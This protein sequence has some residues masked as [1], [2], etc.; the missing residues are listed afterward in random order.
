MAVLRLKQED[1][2]DSNLFKLSALSCFPAIEWLIYRSSKYS[3]NK[4][5]KVLESLKKIKTLYRNNGI[6]Y[7]FNAYAFERLSQNKL[8]KLHPFLFELPLN[9]LLHPLN[10]VTLNKKILKSSKANLPIKEIITPINFKKVK[11]AGIFITQT[12]LNKLCTSLVLLNWEYKKSARERPNEDYLNFFTDKDILMEGNED[13]FSAIVSH[14]NSFSLSESQIRF[15]LNFV[16]RELIF[17]LNSLSTSSVESLRRLFFVAD[18]SIQEKKDE[19]LIRLSPSYSI[20]KES[21]LNN[22]I[23]LEK[24]AILGYKKIKH[25]EFLQRGILECLLDQTFLSKLDQVKKII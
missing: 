11:L 8:F 5:E 10:G 7:Q 3:G 23:L 18:S 12:E 13:K 16:S 17:F 6:D 15:I 20:L 9:T 14:L 2:S 1:I 19:D 22:I 25:I 24:L 21:D 4:K